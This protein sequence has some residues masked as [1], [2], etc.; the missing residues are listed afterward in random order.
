MV[1]AANPKTMVVFIVALFAFTS[2]A[3]GHLPVQAQ[4]LVLGALFSVIALVLDSV[5]AAMASARRIVAHRRRDELALIG[6]TGGLVV[7]RLR[8]RDFAVTSREG[9]RFQLKLFCA[10]HLIS[11]QSFESFNLF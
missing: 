10:N 3:P 11:Q 7:D 9:S 1:R 8:R 5:W 6:G 2:S 4:M